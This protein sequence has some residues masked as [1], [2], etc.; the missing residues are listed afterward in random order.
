MNQELNNENYK[1]YNFEQIC[2]LLC[3]IEN[4]YLTHLNLYRNNIGEKGAEYLAESL[5]NNKFITILNLDFNNIGNKGT[6]YIVES[7]KIR[8]AKNLYLTY[9]NFRFLT[10][11][12]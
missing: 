7:L 9:L 12:H 4:K 3:K 10:S 11:N 5:K 6:R 8:E 1:E 2:E